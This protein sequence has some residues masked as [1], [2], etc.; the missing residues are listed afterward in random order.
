MK[1]GFYDSGL[2]GL[3]VLK[4]FLYKYD[5][6]YSC[7]YYGDTANAPYGD[8]SKEEL[9][10]FIKEIM[11]YMHEA[12]VDLVISACNTTSA[13]LDELDLDDYFFQVLSLYEV[14][15]KYFKESDEAKKYRKGKKLALLATT[16]SINSEKYK[17]WGV[18]IFPLA[19]PKIVPLMEA[20]K[21]EEAK[22]EWKNCLSQ[23][24]SDIKDIIVGCT[25]YSFLYD[26]EDK[27]YNFID[28]AEL[29]VDFFDKS[30]YAD[31]ILSF[32][33]KKSVEGELDIDI[34]FTAGDDDYKNMASS[35]IT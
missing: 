28:P 3:S 15:E 16:S 5:A 7:V 20:G 27:K 21:L 19:C 4:S 2:G 18:D 6:K 24:P 35:L 23:V 25:H 26:K 22:A 34:Y 1:L 11:D 17:K 31:G 29:S 8:K 10:S 13:L 9:K 30:M 14:M 32:D 12:D 33:F